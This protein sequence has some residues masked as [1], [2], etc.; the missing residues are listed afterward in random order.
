[1]YTHRIFRMERVMLSFEYEP[2]VFFQEPKNSNEEE[3]KTN[4]NGVG[5]LGI[6]T[7]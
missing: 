7:T 3:D 5:P 1:M 2:L 4:T 6:I